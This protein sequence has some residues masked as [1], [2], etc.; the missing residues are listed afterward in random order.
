MHLKS[1]DGKLGMH[2]RTEAVARARALT[3]LSH[4][5]GDDL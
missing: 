2:T 1:I 3:L 4:R 5:D